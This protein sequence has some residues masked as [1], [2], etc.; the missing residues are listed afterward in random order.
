MKC[1]KCHSVEPPV[2]NHGTAASERGQVLS[3]DVAR[4]KPEVR[5]SLLRSS[6]TNIHT[7]SDEKELGMGSVG[8]SDAGDRSGTSI[9][10]SPS[11]S[12]GKIE[13]DIFPIVNS[14]LDKS[15]ASAVPSPGLFRI[16][17]V[18]VP[19]RWLPYSRFDHQAHFALPEI[20]E[21]GKGNWCVACHENAPASRKTEDVLLPSI[22]LCR[23]CHME[24]AGAQASCKSCHEFHSPK[25]PDPLASV[26]LQSGPKLASP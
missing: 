4:G 14:T 10:V 20:K 18:Q 12:A 5:P 9:S 26:P 3:E 11:V 22:G 24:P 25:P 1:L 23:N 7:Y 6:Q 2:S 16:A 21:R 13:M 8:S 19:V 15:S 17:R